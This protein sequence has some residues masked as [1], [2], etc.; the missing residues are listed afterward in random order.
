MAAADARA[1]TQLPRNRKS[2]RRYDAPHFD[3]DLF[4]TR[5]KQA[6]SHIC[7][8]RMASSSW[9]PRAHNRHR[10]TMLTSK[11]DSAV[12]VVNDDDARLQDG[13]TD[14]GDAALE[15]SWKKQVPRDLKPS[16]HRDT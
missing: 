1:P 14:N 11:D 15:L 12:R 8:E 16:W 5:N 6:K 7:A 3:K 4:A 10:Y 9:S 13:G 2:T